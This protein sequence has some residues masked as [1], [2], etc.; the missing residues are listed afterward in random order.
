MHQMAI[1]FV[2]AF[3][4]NYFR[5][6]QA[7]NEKVFNLTR[8]DFNTSKLFNI[9]SISILVILAVVT[10]LLVKHVSNNKF[11]ILISNYFCSNC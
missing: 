1:S 2:A 11:N 3:L 10:A 4:V 6:P 5:S 9:G 8:A 7:T